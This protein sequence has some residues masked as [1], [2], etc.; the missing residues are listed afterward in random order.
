VERLLS[1]FPFIF[2]ARCAR[3]VDQSEDFGSPA[4]VGRMVLERIVWGPSFVTYVV[5][6][7][8]VVPFTER[9]IVAP[10]LFSAFANHAVPFQQMPD[11]AKL[12]LVTVRDV[13]LELFVEVATPEL[14]AA[15]H[16]FPFQAKSRISNPGSIA[17]HVMPSADT[18]RFDE[19]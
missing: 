5:P 16:R 13:Q 10:P 17:V 1:E 3:Y 14:V 12:E 19:K 4:V 9:Q 2:T 18:A 15:T 7:V 8:H 11:V 6:R